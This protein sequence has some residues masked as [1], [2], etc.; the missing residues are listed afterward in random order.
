MLINIFSFQT[1]QNQSSLGSLLNSY[2]EV[3][4]ALVNSDAPAAAAKAGQFIKVNNSLELKSVPDGKQNA[5]ITIQ[6][7]LISDAER[8]S[9]AKDLVKQREYFATF[10]QD[11]YSLAQIAKLSDNP[12]YH[13]YCPMKKMYWLSNESNIKNP[14]YG[15]AMLSC[16]QVTETIKP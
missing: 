10:S 7:N 15:N 3:K 12:V 13:Q 2:Y 6:K 14:Y 8:I 4:N 9:T 11:F 1:Q 16:G 5:F